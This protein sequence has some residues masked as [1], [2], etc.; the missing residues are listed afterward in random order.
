MRR[1]SGN[2]GV[3]RSALAVGL[4]VMIAWLALL[5]RIHGPWSLLLVFGGFAALGLAGWR[6]GADSRDGSSWKRRERG[7]IR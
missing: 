2:A 5:T 1:S 3:S 4:A 6:W 7:A